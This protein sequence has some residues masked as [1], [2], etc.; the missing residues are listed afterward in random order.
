MDFGKL[1]SQPPLVAAF[2]LC[3][4]FVF[5]HFLTTP[6]VPRG[7][8][9]DLVPAHPPRAPQTAFLAL[10]NGVA[11]TYGSEQQ[12]AKQQVKKEQKLIKQEQGMEKKEKAH[13]KDEEKNLKKEHKLL[14]QERAAFNGGNV[15]E[16]QKLDKK[17]DKLAKA[18]ARDASIADKVAKEEFTHEAQLATLFSKWSTSVKHPGSK[19]EGKHEKVMNQERKIEQSLVAL[20][21]RQS[22][23]EKAQEAVLEQRRAFVQGR[24][25]GQML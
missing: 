22:R 1:S 11:V 6:A 9:P 10:Q 17:L 4:L 13:I 5:M 20:A 3:T 7:F 2:C 12:Q 15:A 25:Q 16:F 14:D 8:G 23:A 21:R 18:E 19:W 24:P